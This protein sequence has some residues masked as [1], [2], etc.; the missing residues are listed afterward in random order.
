MLKI[1]K[2]SESRIKFLFPLSFSLIARFSPVYIHGR[3]GQNDNLL[4]STY[5]Y[6][7]GKVALE[8]TIFDFGFLKK[9]NIQHRDRQWSASKARTLKMINLLPWGGGGAMGYKRRS[10]LG[11]ICEI[12]TPAR[13]HF[14]PHRWPVQVS[15]PKVRYF[16]H[17][18]PRSDIR[19]M[20][21][22]RPICKCRCPPLI[23]G[24][25]S[26]QFSR[27]EAPFGT[28]LESH[29]AIG[30]LEQASWRGRLKEF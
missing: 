29:A 10:Y 13:N 21:S 27:S 16:T 20:S 15:K 26:E 12:L 11:Q 23:H 24:R 1:K 14:L 18:D 3:D 5:T 8:G 28:T 2:D 22:I 19:S 30:K 7:F 6:T 4:P 17:S 25:L 9:F